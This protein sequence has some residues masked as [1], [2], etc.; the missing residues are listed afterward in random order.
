MEPNTDK[1]EENTWRPKFKSEFSMGQ[2]DFIRYN[3]W[4][5]YVEQYH[6]A[7][8]SS[9][10]PQLDDMQ[11]LFAGLTILFYCWKVLISSDKTRK[12]LKEKFKD[13]KGRKR[14]WEENIKN[15]SPPNTKFIFD[16]QDLLEDLYEQLMEIKQI[17]G[18]GIMV[19]RVMTTK[20]KIMEGIRGEKRL[21]DLP[22]A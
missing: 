4:L 17:I 7:I 16:F 1:T 10:V 19:K 15:G 8:A 22:E 12:E 20:E 3:K 11:K 13:A 6:G 18:L 2:F 9:A 14:K 5:E 21:D